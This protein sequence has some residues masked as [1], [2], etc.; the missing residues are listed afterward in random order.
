M[1]VSC[2]KP[3]MRPLLQE[4]VD[5]VV[6]SLWDSSGCLPHTGCRT[7]GKFLKAYSLSLVICKMGM[8]TSYLAGLL[9]GI[10][11]RSKHLAPY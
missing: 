4:A 7:L 6:E 8:L 5:L 9:R 2:S 10:Q 1:L 11:R 3:P